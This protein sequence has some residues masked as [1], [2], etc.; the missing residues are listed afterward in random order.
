MNTWND[1]TIRLLGPVTLVKGSV[2]IPI[3]GQRQRR[4]LASL[5]L[6][7]GQVI[8]KE[9]IIE[10]SWDGEPPLT[11]S[12]QL[13]TSAWMIR[14]ALAEA[15]LP[16]DALGSHD[17]GYEL[18]VL[19]DS[20]DLFVFREAVRAVRDLHAR[21]QH[22]EASERLDTALALWKGPAFADVTSS[23]LRLRGETLEEERTAAV[24]LRALIDVGLGYYG[25]AITRLSELVDHDPFREDLYVSLMKAYY[26]EGRQADA[27]QVF[28]RA[29][30]ILRE[31]I[32]IS[33]GER[34]TR[35]MQAILR[36]D[37][38]VLRVGT[39]A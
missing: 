10:D 15:G 36:Q 18:R 5:A 31:Q 24:E 13:Q 30:D 37:E 23:R 22:Q 12:G 3:R 25:D 34:M 16:R 6:R 14:T 39:P 28:H 26:A 27:I 32:G 1:V 4:F 17:R 33:P 35:V 2:P 11:V 29:K 19:P 38:Q 7:P 8:S 20:I 9:A 21:G